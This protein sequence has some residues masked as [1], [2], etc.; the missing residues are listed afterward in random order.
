ML[1]CKEYLTF[2]FRS[3]RSMMFQVRRYF[4]KVQE[5]FLQKSILHSSM[6][7]LSREI[8]FRALLR[9]Q[10]NQSNNSFYKQQL[11]LQP[12]TI[13]HKLVYNNFIWTQSK[14]LQFILLST[15]KNIHPLFKYS[16]LIRHP[17]PNRQKTR[18][19]DNSQLNFDIYKEILSPLNIIIRLFVILNEVYDKKDKKYSTQRIRANIPNLLVSFQ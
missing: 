14:I 10:E 4:I 17:Q 15:K 13:R 18:K 11:D 1:M 2:C 3:L 9:K 8:K 7:F 6:M 16:L 5:Q 12:N 19:R